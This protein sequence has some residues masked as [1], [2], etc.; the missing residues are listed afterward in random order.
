M[1][2]TLEQRA[3]TVA[4]HRL[5]GSLSHA[6][7]YIGATRVTV[8]AWIRAAHEPLT[9]Q[10]QKMHERAEELVM[11]RKATLDKLFDRTMELQ[12]RDV[13]TADFRDRTGLLKIV[14]DARLLQAGKPTAITQT[15]T[16][17]EARKQLEGIR[18]ELAERRA[19]LAS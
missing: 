3:E 16:A 10:D 7:R 19:R 6:A 9:D 15:V 17:D 11:V 1:A 14:N 13:P 4:E 2:Y 5:T 8:R 18:D 12:L